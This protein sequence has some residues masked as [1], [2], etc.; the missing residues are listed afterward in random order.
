MPAFRKQYRILGILAFG[1]FI[2]LVYAS[3]MP[4]DFHTGI[5]FQWH[6][7]QALHAWPVNPYARVSGSDILSNLILY[8]PLGALFATYFSAKKYA[9]WKTFSASLLICIAT[10]FSIETVQ[11]F[12]TLRTAS[13]TDLMMNSISGTIGAAA[14]TLCGFPLWQNISASLELRRQS[15]PIDILT[16]LFTGLLVADALSPYLPTLLL[17]EVWHSIKTSYFNPIA[18]FAQH[19]WHWWLVTHVMVYIIFTWMVSQWQMREDSKAGVLHAGLFCSL[20]TIIIECSKIFITSRVVNTANIIANSG[21]IL[22]AVIILHLW[23]HPASSKT[24]LVLGIT[25]LSIY[26]LYIGWTP[27]NFAYSAEA[28][29]ANLPHGV[30]FLPFYHYAMGASLNHVR[31]FIQ[32]IIFSAALIYFVRLLLKH[33]GYSRSHIVLAILISGGIGLLQEGGQLFL[34]SRT[35][36]MTDIYCYM[37]GGLLA[38]RIPLVEDRKA[39]HDI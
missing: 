11:L 31:L 10:S 6:I 19:P 24:R 17:S 28:F 20:F 21:G 25:A 14:G 15:N 23:R 12:S 3:L 38:S 18:G 8:I 34:P 1:Y 13:I 39:K 36:S 16:L 2:L 29:A 32:T 22:L 33:T 35:P 7:N 30:E 27:F 37:L 5:D 26:I 9:R 4:Y